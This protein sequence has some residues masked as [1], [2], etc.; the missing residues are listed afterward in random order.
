MGE[1]F[2]SGAVGRAGANRLQQMRQS[3]FALSCAQC[4][5]GDVPS[6]GARTVLK[7]TA[8]ALTYN[9]VTHAAISTE[10]AA[11]VA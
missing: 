8:V 4:R 9:R 1:L 10:M 11:D 7:E 6:A 3:R 5:A 2:T